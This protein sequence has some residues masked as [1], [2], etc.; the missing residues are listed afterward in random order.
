MS[1][2]KRADVAGGFVKFKSAEGLRYKPIV[3][4]N[5]VL[6]PER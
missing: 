4:K 5:S 3:L 2:Q 6:G 1:V